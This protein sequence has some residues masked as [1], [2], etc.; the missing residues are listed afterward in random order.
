[1]RNDSVDEIFKKAMQLSEEDRDKFLEYLPEQQR[2]SK[3]KENEE[4]LQEE[5]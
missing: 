5:E 1:M 2:K 3:E 4:K